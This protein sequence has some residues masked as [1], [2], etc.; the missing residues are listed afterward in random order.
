MGGLPEGLSG[1]MESSG[2]AER[3]LGAEAG[4]EPRARSAPPPRS[5]PRARRWVG[6]T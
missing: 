6:E 4:G 2:C 1:L 5:H 3:S